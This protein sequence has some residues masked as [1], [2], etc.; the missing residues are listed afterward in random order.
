[1]DLATL[2]ADEDIFNRTSQAIRE[3]FSWIPEKRYRENRRDFL[4]T[5]LE[6]ERLYITDHMRELFEEQARINLAREI[7]LMGE[8]I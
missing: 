1:M 4:K 8:E 6:R 3:E 7:E 5:F 2:G